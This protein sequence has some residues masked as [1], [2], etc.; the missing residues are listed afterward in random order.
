MSTGAHGSVTSLYKKDE[1]KSKADAVEKEIDQYNALF[2]DDEN[3]EKRKSQYMMM[4]N[5]FYDVVTDFYEYGWGHSFHFANRYKDEGFQESVKRSEYFL[6]LKLCLKPGMKVLDIGCGIGGPMRSV[7]KFSSARITGVNNN[8]YQIKRGRRLNESA[9]LSHLCDFIQSDFMQLKVPPQSYDA[10]FAVEA[11]CHAPDK[12]ACFLEIYKALKPGA[13]FA[14]YEWVLTDKYDPNNAEHRA[15]KFGIEEGNGLP[16]I[17]HYS[18]V[19]QAM[20]DAGFKVIETLDTQESAHDANQIPWYRPLSADLTLDGFVHT[21]WGHMFTTAMLYVLETVGLAP[22]GSVK[23]QDMLVKTAKFL[24]KSGELGIFS[25]D[26]LV[27]AQKP[28]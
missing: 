25:P 9:G 16:P 11:T 10:A 2:V 19:I 22:K 13:L 26:F 12:T 15:I 3:G 7:A 21:A 6:A 1:F 24:V 27:L 17:P 8:E 23:V 4:V 14:V 28:L 5:N 18:V 20:K